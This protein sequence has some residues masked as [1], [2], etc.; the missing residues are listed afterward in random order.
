MR[1]NPD[2]LLAELLQLPIHERVRLAESLIASLDQ[3]SP[4]ERAWRA[5]VG[6]R[7]A[8]LNAGEARTRPVSDVLRDLRSGDRGPAAE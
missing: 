2:L 8:A 7:V 3:D 1:T 5:E 6:R 4:V